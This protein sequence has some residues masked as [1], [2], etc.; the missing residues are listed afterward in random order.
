MAVNNR[1]PMINATGIWELRAPFDTMLSK[2]ARYTCISVTKL[3][4]LESLGEE[5][6]ENHYAPYSLDKTAYQEDLTA[7]VCIITVR[8]ESGQLYAFPSSYLVS[9]P[10]GNGVEYAVIGLTAILGPLPVDT[11]LA[12]I[13]ARMKELVRD[14]VGVEN[15]VYSMIVS[16]PEVL[17]FDTHEAMTAS[18]RLNI[19]ES[20][21]DGARVK[22]LE[23]ELNEARARIKALEKGLIDLKNKTP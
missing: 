9:F 6:Y 20:T 10:S 1:L 13:K 22:S 19:K 2:V 21:T 23:R 18:R 5:P 16:T 14:T 8:S 15:D 12:E 7:Q 3:E 11:N 17:A 4:K